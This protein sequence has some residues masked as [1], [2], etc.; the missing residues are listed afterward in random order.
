[1]SQGVLPAGRVGFVV[2]EPVHDEL[3]DVGEGQHPLG[4]VPQRHRRQ[5]NVGVRGLAV[6]VGLPAGPRH[7]VG[8][9]RGGGEA[10]AGSLCPGAGACS[11]VRARLTAWP[12]PLLP[13]ALLSVC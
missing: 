12:R 5:R 6:A 1:M 13:P 8:G 7:R 2:G 10:G 11:R 9:V 4:R 3:V